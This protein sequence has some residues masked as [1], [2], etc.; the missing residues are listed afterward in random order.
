M[1]KVIYV[2]F[3]SVIM[4]PFALFFKV[5]GGTD[6]RRNCCC[7][8]PGLERGG[9]DHQTFNFSFMCLI[10]KSVHSERTHVNRLSLV[11]TS[12]CRLVLY[13]KTLIIR[14]TYL[15]EFDWDRRMVYCLGG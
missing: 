1:K 13:N 10:A 2:I 4:I 12:V 7:G 9:G 3:V 6:S 11:I 5:Y 15:M 8:L 14:V